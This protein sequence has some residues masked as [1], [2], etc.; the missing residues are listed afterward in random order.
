MLLEQNVI[1]QTELPFLAVIHALHF[2]CDF[3]DFIFQLLQ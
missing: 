1:N 3:G 2:G